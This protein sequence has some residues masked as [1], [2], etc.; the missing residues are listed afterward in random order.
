MNVTELARKLKITTN[1][2]LAKLPEL[3]FDIGRRAIKISPDLVDKIITAVEADRKKSK[4]AASEQKVTE[5]KLSDKDEVAEPVKEP[6]KIIKI[7]QVIAVKDFAELLEL[8]VVKVIAELMKNG[9]MTSMN[10]RIDLA[11][12]SII[13][14]DLGF[15]V[16]AMTAEEAQSIQVE[17]T[18]KKLKEVLKNANSANAIVRPPVVVVMG[19]VDHGKTKLLD[20][21]RE[22][23]IVDQESGGITQHIGAYQVELQPEHQQDDKEIPRSARDNFSDNVRKITFLD[24]P[25]HEAFKSM[26]SRGSKIADV[27]II[28]VAADDGLKPQTMEVI[29]LVQQE[30]LPFVVAINKIDKEGADVDRV[31]K[32]LSEINLIPEDWGGKTV[33][34]P[35]SAKAKTGLSELLDMVILVSELEDLKADPTGPAVGTIIES[36][37]DKGEGP[38]ATVLV[39]A[40]TLRAGDLI[41]VGQVAGKVRMLKNFKGEDVASAGPSMPVKIVGLKEVP[42]VGEI[43]EVTADKKI[44]KEMLKKAGYKKE[45]NLRAADHAAAATAT[46]DEDKAEVPTLN[47]VLKADV[48]GSEEAILESLTRFI[49]PEVKVK[50]IKKGLGNVT[51][52]DVLAAEASHALVVAFRVKNFPTAEQLARD[53][54]VEIGYYEIIYKLLEEIEARLKKLLQPQIIR[55]ELGKI[56]ILAVFRTEKKSMIAGGKILE[57]RVKP[58]TKAKV[59]RAGEFVVMGELAELRA[60]KEI[61]AEAMAGEQCGFKFIGEPVIKEHD[62]LEI[63]QEEIKERQLQVKHV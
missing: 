8:P 26:R 59:I 17:A 46:E 11:T 40:G 9:I 20:A 13:G 36:H 45:A 38:V 35:I 49:D 52:A 14:E 47:L 3:G 2:L 24:T 60:G 54:K 33:C 28:V 43:L 62:V 7:P 30:Q 55:T 22:T 61:V 41:V 51:D 31:K 48:L 42:L 58:N 44:V 1:E 18:D 57:G 63:Y 16:E 4:I 53:K 39:Q 5:I 21:I 34:V 23:N 37:I 25:G 10:E 15:K 50:V 27:A 32:E 56:Q 6:G 19:H 29:N 12:A